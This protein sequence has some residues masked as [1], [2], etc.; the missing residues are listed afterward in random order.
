VLIID[1]HNNSQTGK[2]AVTAKG[3]RLTATVGLTGA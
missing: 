3:E 2:L 1:Q